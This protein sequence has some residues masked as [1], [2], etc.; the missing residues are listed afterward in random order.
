MASLDVAWI[1]VFDEVYR[2]GSVSR[3]AENLD[4]SQGAASTA[5]QRLRRYYGDPLF[6]RT[7]RGM[8][9]TPRADALYPVLC[10]VRD[11]LEAARLG[12]VGFE[13]ET[14]ERTFRL[15]MTDLGE[16]SLL[17]RLLNEFRTLA[18][19]VRLV[20]EK[21]GRDTPREL[22]EGL[23][24]LA[25]GYMPQ[26]DA[27]FYQHVVFEQ[28]YRCIVAREHPRVGEQLELE[29]FHDE[30]HVEVL[31]TATGHS[32]LVESTLASLGVSRSVALY[33]PS[34]LAVAQIVAS[35]DLVATVPDYYARL[36]SEQVPIRSVKPP[37]IL[38]RYA[39]KQHWHTRFHRE[40]GNI[41]LR[42]TIARLMPAAVLESPSSPAQSLL[43]EPRSHT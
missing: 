31:T 38:P 30:L 43:T 10:H 5:L 25:V 29:R 28:G 18:P 6:I 17:P 19:G 8:L 7:A 37:F 35:T 33:V 39:V 34:F 11:E 4:I 22:E 16:I 3:A 2:T 23:L 21:I 41:W 26:L 36:M 32:N 13:P 42:R 9:P 15:C 1:A 24:D 12:A 14:S 20:A 40:S 27:G